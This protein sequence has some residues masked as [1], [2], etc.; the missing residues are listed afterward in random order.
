[1]KMKFFKTDKVT[2]YDNDEADVLELLSKKINDEIPENKIISINSEIIKTNGTFL[3]ATAIVS[4]KES[5][6]WEE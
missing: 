3:H 5:K 4:Y 6:P 1:M 2:S